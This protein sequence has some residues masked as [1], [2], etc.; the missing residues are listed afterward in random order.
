MLSVSTRNPTAECSSVI[1][2]GAPIRDRFAVRG[3]VPPHQSESRPYIL[4]TQQSARAP[5]RPCRQQCRM[6]GRED[7]LPS[8]NA[9]RFPLKPCLVAYDKC[10]RGIRW[11]LHLG[12][13]CLDLLGIS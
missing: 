7:R 12:S 1:Y 8:P 13:N 3:I 10:C 6:L 11:E 2:E 9:N 4:P 5:H